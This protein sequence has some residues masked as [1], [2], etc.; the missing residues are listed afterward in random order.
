MSKLKLKTCQICG[1]QVNKK[2][3]SAHVAQYHTNDY[4]EFDDKL[5]AK[6]KDKISTLSVKKQKTQQ[7]DSFVF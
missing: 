6:R 3:L 7:D 2:E 4:D 5:E 1:E